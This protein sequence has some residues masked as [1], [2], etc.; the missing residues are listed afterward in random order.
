[1]RQAGSST[2]EEEARR[3]RRRALSEVSSYFKDLT[4]ENDVLRK[5]NGELREKLRSVRAP[6]LTSHPDATGQPIHFPEISKQNAKNGEMAGFILFGRELHGRAKARRRS[7]EN[8]ELPTAEKLGDAWKEL[9][10]N[11]KDLFSSRAVFMQTATESGGRHDETA[12]ESGRRHDE[13]APAQMASKRDN[14]SIA[15][16]ASSDS[17]SD[18]GASSDSD[19][20]SKK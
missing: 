15:I 10:D 9:P 18:S 17:D 2:P 5:E 3:K 19:S 6:G 12:T 1:M 7:G 8:I 20:D 14:Q 13:T 16:C 4:D 11:L